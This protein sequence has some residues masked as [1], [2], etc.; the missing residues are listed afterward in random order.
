MIRLELREVAN[1]D[2][3]RLRPSLFPWAA[4]AHS[5][6]RLAKAD[7]SIEAVT[8]IP[9]KLISTAQSWPRLSCL[10]R[11]C[12]SSALLRPPQLA[13]ICHRLRALEFTRTHATP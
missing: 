1:R 7:A 10:V 12:V 4:G 6:G 8:S 11:V 5:Y 13:L 3:P 2:D 9:E